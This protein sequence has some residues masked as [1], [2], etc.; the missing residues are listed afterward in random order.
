MVFIKPSIIVDKEMSAE[1]SS[2][3]YNY[4][5]ALQKLNNDPDELIDLTETKK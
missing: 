4:I 5:K 2:E 3:K 1:L